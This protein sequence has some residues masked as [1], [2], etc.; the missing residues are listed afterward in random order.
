MRHACPAMIIAMLGNIAVVVE[1]HLMANACHA[2]MALRI[3]CTS[4][5]ENLVIAT[6]AAGVVA[7]VSMLSDS[8]AIYEFQITNVVM[9][10]A[11]FIPR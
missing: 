11:V 10:V 9:S 7:K 4:V 3:L 6:I 2:Q 1:V 5:Q 8:I